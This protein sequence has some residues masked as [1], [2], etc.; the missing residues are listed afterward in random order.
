MAQH[1]KLTP[2]KT[3]ATEANAHKA[4]AE[5]KFPDTCRYVVLKNDEGRFYPLFI[6]NSAIAAMVH[7]SFCVAN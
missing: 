6:G 1:L 3:Y 7:F 2:A 4:V 5:K